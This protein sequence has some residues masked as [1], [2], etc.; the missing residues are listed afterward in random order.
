MLDLAIIVMM[1]RNT[2][3]VDVNFL[4][5]LKTLITG[6]PA[7]VLRG[8]SGQVQHLYEYNNKFSLVGSGFAAGRF[9]GFWV[10][11]GNVFQKH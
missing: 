10:L 2:H 6:F 8:C 11:S 9:P 4:N 1:Y 3:S 5:R 7:Q